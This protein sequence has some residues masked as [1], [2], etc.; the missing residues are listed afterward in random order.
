MD[1]KEDEMTVMM[2]QFKTLYAKYGREN[3]NSSLQVKKKNDKNG[4]VYKYQ[5]Q[6][7]ECSFVIQYLKRNS[8]NNK[9]SYRFVGVC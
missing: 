5:A 8:N 7:T 9:K 1:I 6:R 4:Y 2:Q 3:T